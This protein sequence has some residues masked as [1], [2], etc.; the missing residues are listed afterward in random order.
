MSRRQL[1]LFSLLP[2]AFLA[3]GWSSPPNIRQADVDRWMTEL[4]N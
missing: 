2:A 4:S 3:T 1:L